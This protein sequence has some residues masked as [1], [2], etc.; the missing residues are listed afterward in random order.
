MLL[1]AAVHS[2]SFFITPVAQNDTERQL[3]DLLQ[4]YR[5]DMGAGFHRSTANLFTALSACVPLL[6]VLAP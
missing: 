6:F 3:H 4:N 1:S 5:A 2:V